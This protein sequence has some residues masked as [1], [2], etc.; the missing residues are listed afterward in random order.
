MARMM[1]RR[2]RS[3]RFFATW[4][5]IALVAAIVAPGSVV[6][7]DDGGPTADVG[8]VE[9]AAEEGPA[10]EETKTE[11]EPEAPADEAP[12]AQEPR[13][14][15]AA[16]EPAMAEQSVEAAPVT[17]A[18][19]VSLAPP[20][21]D[22][23]EPDDVPATVPE[24]VYPY[25]VDGNPTCSEY[26]NFKLEGVPVVGT[27]TAPDDGP[28]LPA[29]ASI[30]ITA[31]DDYHFSFSASG[32]VIHGV[33][34]KASNGAN[35][36]SYP[37]PG[38]SADGNLWSVRNW[39]GE[40][41]QISHIT[42]CWSEESQDVHIIAKKFH[43]ED[44]SGTRDG[45]EA[46]LAGFTFKLYSGPDG[47]GPWTY[48]TEMTSVAPN[49]QADFGM[50]PAGWYKLVEVLT[51]AQQAAGWTPTTGDPLGEFIFEHSAEVNSEKRFGN[52]IVEPPLGALVVHKFEDAAIE[53]GTWDEA[54]GELK[55]SGWEFTVKNS[56]G[57]VIATGTTGADG[58]IAFSGL[59]PGEYTVEETVKDG[60]YLTTTQG[61]GVTVS[62]ETTANAWFG[63]HR[64][65]Y[66]KTF[67]FTYPDKPVGVDLKVTFDLNGEPKSLWLTGEGPVYSAEIDVPYPYAI[68]NVVWWADGPD[69]LVALGE[70]PGETLEGDL[71]NEFEYDPSLS[72]HKFNDYSEDGI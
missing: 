11:Q 54:E 37:M 51:P 41:H 32:V 12:P 15:E 30:S 35:I 22:P 24:G 5:T 27:Y 34:V 25:Y 36:Y 3:V 31:A 42:F 46:W 40:Y 43:D 70:T 2:I 58:T 57:S 39:N 72:G 59:E 69:G 20:V 1:K 28:A 16:S 26:N 45:G 53:N 66:V 64:D 21:Q 18:L 38:V 71:T 13:S 56:Q 48:L 17:A 9:K 47:D 14:D 33:I 19:V 23:V 29:G 62:A 68:T 4:L 52:V 60:W 44:S 50:Y 6:L 67:E 65:V 63:N 8:V 55:L 7:A 10:G 49:G 61:L